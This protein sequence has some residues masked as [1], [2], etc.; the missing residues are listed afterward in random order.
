MRASV[1]LHR[2]KLHQRRHLSCLDKKNRKLTKHVLLRCNVE[3]ISLSQR[4]GVCLT[5]MHTQKTHYLQAEA[6]KGEHDEKAS[7]SCV[8][9]A[10]DTK[11]EYDGPKHIL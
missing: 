11:H 6:L 3:A 8:V 9:E 7:K 4:T 2:G 10:R 5:L 1:H